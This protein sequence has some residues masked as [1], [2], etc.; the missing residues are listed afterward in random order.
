[1]NV[2]NLG[3]PVDDALPFDAN[4]YVHTE[5]EEGMTP[6]D[7][8]ATTRE[9]RRALHL[10]QEGLADLAGCSPEFVG[11]LE[12]GKPGVRL[13]KVLDVL[14]ALGLELRVAVAGAHDA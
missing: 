14:T 3:I 6:S 8:G 13:D 1:M 7:L 10:T 2:P 11:L 5:S 9:R 4:P 12:K